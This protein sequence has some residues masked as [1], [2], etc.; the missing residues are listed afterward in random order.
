MLQIRLFCLKYHCYFSIFKLF[1]MLSVIYFILFLFEDR[2]QLLFLFCVQKLLLASLEMI[3]DAGIKPGWTV[4]KVNTLP[5]YYHS[6][7]FLNCQGNLL[8]FLFLYCPSSPYCTMIFDSLECSKFSIM[9]F[10]FM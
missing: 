3:W 9:F 8:L 2:T 6:R 7:Q 4:Y 1:F 5:L 10:F